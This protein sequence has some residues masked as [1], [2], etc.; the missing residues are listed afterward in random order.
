MAELP[1]AGLSEGCLRTQTVQE[2]FHDA[3]F[4]ELG[5]DLE[6]HVLQPLSR[7]GRLEVAAAGVSMDVAGTA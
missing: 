6:H 4:C 5:L 1:S 3:F 2:H 7:G